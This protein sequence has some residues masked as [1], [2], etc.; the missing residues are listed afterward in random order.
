MEVDF[1]KYANSQNIEV[2]PA[3]TYKV[4]LN[5][6]EKCIAKTSTEQIRWYATVDTPDE[7]KDKPLIDH[8]ALTEAAGWRIAWFVADALNWDADTMKQV[9]RIAVGSAK[10]NRLMDLAKG[11][12]MYWTISIDPTYN[13]NKVA[14][15][16]KDD[17]S[18]PVDLDE[19]DDIPDFL[20]DN[21]EPKE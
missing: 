4:T 5:K 17:T 6:W 12:S 8:L 2:L 21:K 13:N 19:L 15:Y 9:G 16:V 10:F 18:D 3:Q 20:R 7:H 14:E 11:R 1:G